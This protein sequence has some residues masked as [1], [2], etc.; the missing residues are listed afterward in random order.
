MVFTMI[1]DELSALN[2]H[3]CVNLLTSYIGKIT[4]LISDQ[5][6]AFHPFAP[7]FCTLFL[8]YQTQI[9]SVYITYWYW[10]TST[11]VTRKTNETKETGETRETRER[12][13]AWL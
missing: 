10:L 12:R 8:D 11:Q 5:Q 2:V 7:L 3:L 6:S 13:K 1:T 9:S 4:L